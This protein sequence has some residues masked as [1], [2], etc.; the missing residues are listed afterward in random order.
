MRRVGSHRLAPLV[1]AGLV[2][3]IAG[4]VYGGEVVGGV[5]GAAV[6]AGLITY[7]AVRRLKPGRA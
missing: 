2:L 4:P 5:Y 7:I 1:V 3:A 6:A